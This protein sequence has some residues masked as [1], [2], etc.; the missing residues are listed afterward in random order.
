[1]YYAG[2]GVEFLEAGHRVETIFAML[3]STS[4]FK[5]SAR[6]RT[7][8]HCFRLD[9]TPLVDLAFLLLTFFL[10]HTSITKPRVMQLVMPSMGN[11]ANRH[12]GCFGGGLSGAA[13]IILG[14]NHQLHYY[15]GMNNPL[16]PSLPVPE[17]STT[18]FGPQG[19][20]QALLA[21][22]SQ[23]PKL[24]VLIKPGPQ[25]TYQDLVDMLDEMS[26]TD[27]SRYALMPISSADQKLL[28][29]NGQQ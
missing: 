22:H 20:R 13:T 25:A 16:D 1:V 7:S 12:F 10:L 26:I 9:M 29:A 5:A 27:Q 17:L 24:V 15:F 19:I 2:Q 18:D 6:L 14:R 23:L 21:W 11:L 28:V 4:T 3:M 8:W